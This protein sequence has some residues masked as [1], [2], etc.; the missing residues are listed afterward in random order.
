ML[1]HHRWSIVNW[2]CSYVRILSNATT[3]FT[4]WSSIL[5][6]TF[7]SCN[8]RYQ[9]FCIGS[10]MH[11]IS[12]KSNMTMKN[13]KVRCRGGRDDVKNEKSIKYHQTNTEINSTIFL[14]ADKIELLVFSYIVVVQSIN[15]TICYCELPLMTFAFAEFFF[16]EVN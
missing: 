13:T 2:T 10:L 3:I 12:P 7:T 16:R 14:F 11:V 9:K 8:Y 6:K 5:I 15:W 1:N 4:L